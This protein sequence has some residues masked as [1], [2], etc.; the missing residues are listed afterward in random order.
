MEA[1][2][3]VNERLAKQYPLGTYKDKLGIEKK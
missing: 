1:K 3:F 2:R